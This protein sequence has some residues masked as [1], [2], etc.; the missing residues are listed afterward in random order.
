M[1]NEFG[2]FIISRLLNGDIIEYIMTE[3]TRS[4]FLVLKL[5]PQ[6]ILRQQGKLYSDHVKVW[7]TTCKRFR[8]ESPL[9]A[10]DGAVWVLALFISKSEALSERLFTD[11]YFRQKVPTSWS[12]PIILN[13]IISLTRELNTVNALKTKFEELCD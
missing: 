5:N 9:S 2:P 7:S 4:K 6:N 11:L 10:F 13:I 3:T 1:V 8:K 12:Y